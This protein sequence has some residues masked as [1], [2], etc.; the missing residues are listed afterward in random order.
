MAATV[1][2]PASTEEER[3][4]LSDVS[5]RT[6]ESLLLD[7]VDRPVPRFTYHRGTLELL[8][9]LSTKHERAKGLLTTLVD[10]VADVRGIEVL[11]AGSMTFKRADLASGFE[12]DVTFYI[13][14]ARQVW[15][16][17]QIDPTTD[18]P[19]DLVIEIDVSRRSLN[20]LPIYAAFGVPEV[21][22]ARD[23]IV[24]VY[25]LRPDGSGTYDEGGPSRA[26]PPLDGVTLTRFLTDGLTLGRAAWVRSIR[27]WANSRG[28][29]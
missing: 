29:K 23:G 13:Q 9:I 6:Y 25:T 15:D 24:I 14:N 18:P 11:N 3:V 7:R 20:K 10:T 8:V 22:R 16:R 28:H 21:W 2:S 4:I 5:W 27:A 19:P 26:L 12:P 1:M 17:E